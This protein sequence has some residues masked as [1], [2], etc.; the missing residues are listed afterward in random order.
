M[1]ELRQARGIRIAAK[2]GA[3]LEGQGWR[4][5]SEANPGKRY[6]VNPLAQTCTCPDHEETNE[7][8]KHVYAVLHI[9]TTKLDEVG[10]STTTQTQLTYSQDWSSYNTAQTQEK[11]TFMALLADLCASVPQPPQT[12]GRP[13]LPLSDM[14]Y[15]ATFKVYSRF[16]SRRFA[17]DLR[18]AHARGHIS[19]VPHFNSVTNYMAS[20][21]LTPILHDLIVESAIPLREL[22]SDFAADSTG[23]STNR[24]IKWYDQKYGEV[25]Q[26]RREWVKAH[27]MVGTRTNVVTSIELSDWKGGDTS[28]FPA[29]VQE[30]AKN[31][32][33]AEVSADK[34]YLTKVNCEIVEEI[35]ATPYI[36]FKKNTKPVLGIGSA[37]AR[38]YHRFAADPEVFEAHYHRRSNVETTFSMIKGKFGDAV[39]SKSPVGQTNEV[40]CKVLAHNIVVVGKAAV[41]CGFAPSFCTERGAAAQE[42]TA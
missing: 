7:P 37:W 14:V 15:A 10:N 31:F 35:G 19:R 36:P 34:A 30:T 22:E 28:Y 42:L 29:L 25:A 12:T 8:C 16:S 9:M 27:V 2:G 24:F 32:D 4:V 38:M 6:R 17:S 23:F 11:D 20:E 13:R 18:E 33:V 26:T 40:L 3:R 5:N 39:M 21:E 41:E 1:C